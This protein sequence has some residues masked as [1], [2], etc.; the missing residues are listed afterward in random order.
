VKSTTVWY[1]R[2]E[3]VCQEKSRLSPMFIPNTVDLSGLLV[4]NGDR[5]IKKKIFCT[6][7]TN[8]PVAHFFYSAVCS[9]R[10]AYSST[11]EA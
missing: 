5:S 11:N 10:T 2:K 3:K 6:F 1:K 7:C 4:R 9:L 8:V